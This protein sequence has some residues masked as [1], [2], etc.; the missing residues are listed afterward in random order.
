VDVADCRW[1]SRTSAVQWSLCNGKIPPNCDVDG[2]DPLRPLHVDT[3]EKLEFQPRSQFRRPLAASMEISLGA[4]AERPV[5]P[6]ATLYWA[7]LRQLLVYT[8][9]FARMRDFIGTSISEFSTIFVDSGRSTPKIFYTETFATTIRTIS[10]LSRQRPSAN[11]K[12]RP[13]RKHVPLQIPTP[14]GRYSAARAPLNRK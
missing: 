14:H 4:S 2:H 8:T 7:L 12:N 13:D 10:G 6:R 5:L 1:T 9:L 3:V 11:S